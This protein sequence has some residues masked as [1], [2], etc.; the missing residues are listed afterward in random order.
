MN[1]RA[2]AWLLAAAAMAV[3]PAGAQMATPAA[4]EALA[5]VEAPA[6]D[7]PA[8]RLERSHDWLYLRMQRFL[9]DLDTQF[10]QA[11][12]APLVV[13]ASPLRLGLDGEWLHGAPGHDAALR[14]DIEATLRLPNIEQR[15]RIFVSSNDLPESTDNTPLEHNPVRAGLRFAPQTHLNVD[16]GVRIKL[17]PSVYA[18][19][20]W[21]PDFVLG[22]VG[23][24]PF[25]KPYVESGIG[26]GTSGGVAIQY[27][28][29]RWFLRSASYMNWTR[30]TSAT[31]WSQSLL[32][33]H[34]EA[35]ISENRYESVATGHDLACGTA[36][37]ALATGD[38][39]QGAS[40]YE[41]SVI[42]KRPLR[43]GWLYGY[44]EPLVHWERTTNWHPE[45]G[46]RIGFDA[47]FW[48]LASTSSHIASG[49]H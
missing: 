18:A 37:H 19:I 48:G 28:R 40:V 26:L 13:P 44:L 5:P 34:A 49:C 31:Q 29:E 27:W 6:A 36:L 8:G 47:L 16:L 24:Q 14:P 25:V 42:Q 9:K 12:Q 3:A 23:F 1:T 39:L 7:G 30:N 4:A 35:V 33:G 21:T 2:L 22:P 20:R 43:G 41:L 17:K 15:F 11:D 38:H 32:F 45:A 46:L 10:S